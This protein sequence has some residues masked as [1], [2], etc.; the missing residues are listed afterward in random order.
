[1]REI[2]ITFAAKIQILISMIKKLLLPALALVVFAACQN[3]GNNASQD[4]SQQQNSV[5]AELKVDPATVKEASTKATASYQKMNSLAQKINDVAKQNLSDTQRS[6]LES[7]RHQL[8]DLMTKQE[9]MMKGLD[10]AN[11]AGGNESSSLNNQVP[12]PGVLKDYVE[13]VGNYDKLVDDFTAQIDALQ[14]KK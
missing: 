12:P 7:I 5:P 9:T 6:D 13:S 14:N 2:S 10:A 4:P 8:D 1:M 3:S 11:S